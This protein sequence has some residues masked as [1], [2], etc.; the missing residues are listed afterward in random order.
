MLDG[1]AKEQACEPDRRAQRCAAQ[2]A[3]Q[4]CTRPGGIHQRSAGRNALAALEPKDF[5]TGNDP[6]GERDFESFMVG[7]RKCFFKIDYY[8]KDDLQHGSEDPSDP[9]KTTRVLTL[10]LA[11]E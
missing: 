1:K 6:Y 7:E 5:R 10:M 2:A 4:S 11:S 8:A 9:T 3:A